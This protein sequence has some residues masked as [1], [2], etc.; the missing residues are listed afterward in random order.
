VA[1]NSNHEQEIGAIIMTTT[2][3]AQ[4]S[5]RPGARRQLLIRKAAK[6][7]EDS[8]QSGE[9]LEASFPD[10]SDVLSSATASPDVPKSESIAASPPTIGTPAAA[11]SDTDE[12]I[13]KT[14]MARRK[15]AGYLTRGRDVSAQVIQ[16]GA[17]KP[18]PDTIVAVIV[19]LVSA[20]GTVSRATLIDAMAGA[21]FPHP[22]AQPSDR[23]WCQGYVAGAIRNGF[24]AVAG[25]GSDQKG[26]GSI[27]RAAQ[28]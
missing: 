2:N 4:H 11:W 5:V 3:A 26:E 28:S 18:N 17:I 15:A 8:T 10:A 21:A 20:K 1:S 19:G 24:L 12:A 25:E 6:Q 16:P 23:S 27:A 22:K 14:L 7:A 13:L 9:P